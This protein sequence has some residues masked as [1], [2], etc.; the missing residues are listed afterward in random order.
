MAVD[1]H[2]VARWLTAY[3]QAWETYAPEAIGA[4]F[5]AD[6]TY[7]WHPWDTEPVRGRDAIVKAW[8]GDQ[9]KSGTYRAHYEPLAID[10]NLAIATGK[11]SYFDAS[12]A[13]ERE[14]HNCFV[15]RFDA[16]GRC[17][18]FT[19]WYMQAPSPH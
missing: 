8:L 13:L 7:A 6:A 4:L 10:G 2:T 5:S 17:S 9:D 18:A 15:M 19:E 3:V 1:Q 12:G 14:F 16:D 11:S